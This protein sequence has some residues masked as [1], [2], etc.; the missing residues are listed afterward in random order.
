MKQKLS[1]WRQ[2]DKS[3]EILKIK[4][5]T[6]QKTK[7]IRTECDNQ[8]AASLLVGKRKTAKNI[9]ELNAEHK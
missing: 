6:D 4:K 2:H 8:L 3:K 1:L 5:E 9:E 7:A